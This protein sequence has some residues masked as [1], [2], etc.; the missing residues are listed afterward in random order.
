MRPFFAPWHLLRRRSA[1]DLLPTDQT[2]QE[3]TTLQT[4]AVY[5]AAF[6]SR[7]I[8]GVFRVLRDRAAG[9]I[10][11]GNGLLGACIP[12]VSP[13]LPPRTPTLEYSIREVD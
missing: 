3:R 4:G 11:T 5:K 10:G 6:S 1:P 9:Q 7:E 2:E 12:G 8:G 13:K